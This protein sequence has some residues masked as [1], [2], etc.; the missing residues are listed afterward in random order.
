MQTPCDLEEYLRRCSRLSS[1]GELAAGVAHNFG[2]V[3]MSISTSLE[4]LQMR[5]GP[6]ET[7]KGA[8]TQVEH[9][10]DLVQRLLALSRDGV[11]NRAVDPARVVK[12]ALVLCSTHP[13]AKCMEL[14]DETPERPPLVCGDGVRIEEVLVNLIL[15]AVQASDGGCVRV[16]VRVG[17]SVEIY[18]S[19]EGCG[20]AEE[21]REKIFE[22][23]YSNR[24]H[25][26]PGTG[27]GLSCS[28][29]LVREMGGRIEVASEPGAGSTFTVVLK[30]WTKARE[31]RS[32]AS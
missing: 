31:K 11:R 2:N 14:V 20:I 13:A 25:G 10:A 30:R 22:P 27:L 4:L 32:D 7:I 16:G 26:T 19:D 17:E 12:T 18:V 29:S 5:Y 6:D 21:E 3:L 23:F 1:M 24:R 9:A 28:L 15:N 8:R